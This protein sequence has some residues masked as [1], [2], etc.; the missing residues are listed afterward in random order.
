MNPLDFVCDSCG[1]R[2]CDCS[3]GVK[4]RARQIP[5]AEYERRVNQS[6]A[7]PILR[8]TRSMPNPPKG[9]A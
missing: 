5:R 9:A 7:W 8:P 2:V 4:R 3:E 1:Q 6:E